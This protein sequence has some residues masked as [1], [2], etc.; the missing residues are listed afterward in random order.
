VGSDDRSNLN[1]LETAL[2]I[3]SSTLPTEW[4]AT[5]EKETEKEFAKPCVVPDSSVVRVY[6]PE[7]SFRHSTDVSEDP[8][9][10]KG[11]A[12]LRC[13]SVDGKSAKRN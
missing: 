6:K 7:E 2:K 12:N 3:A 10:G 11:Q 13:A 5:S 1:T 9:N 8:W 4:Q